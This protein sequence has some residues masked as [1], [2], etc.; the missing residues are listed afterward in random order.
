M[1]SQV[2]SGKELFNED[3]FTYYK[4]NGDLPTAKQIGE[5]CGVSEQSVSRTY[6]TFKE[7]LIKKNQ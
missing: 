6:K 7:K 4:K 2:L 3:I 1:A 5:Q